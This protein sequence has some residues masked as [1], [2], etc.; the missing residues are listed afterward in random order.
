M[1]WVRKE[2]K[3]ASPV[4]DASLHNPQPECVTSS[5]RTIFIVNSLASQNSREM[6][7]S[8]PPPTL[9]ELLLHNQRMKTFAI[10]RPNRDLGP[11]PLFIYR[12]DFW[13][14]YTHLLSRYGKTTPIVHDGS[15][16]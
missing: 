14:A 2:R 6:L 3:K 8:S 11:S 10:Q 12:N 16:F 4:V 13:S 7:I 1:R 5:Q 15:D 9:Q